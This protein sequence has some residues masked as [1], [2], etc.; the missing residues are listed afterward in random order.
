MVSF[1]ATGVPDCG[2]WFVIRHDCVNPLLSS[3]TSCPSGAMAAT[4]RQIQNESSLTM[5]SSC[6]PTALGEGLRPAQG[7]T[8]L[9]RRGVIGASRRRE[10]ERRDDPECSEGHSPMTCDYHPPMPGAKLPSCP[11]SLMSRTSTWYLSRN[12]WP[13]AAASGPPS[14]SSRPSSMMVPER[15]RYSARGLTVIDFGGRY[16]ST[17]HK[18]TLPTTRY[19]HGGS[20]TPSRATSRDTLGNPRARAIR[21]STSISAYQPQSHPSAGGTC[22]GMA[23]PAVDD[24]VGHEMAEL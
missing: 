7:G 16:G 3:M 13:N 19:D 14:V 15:A 9:L 5:S 10:R 1:S 24:F 21:S 8:V 23:H 12:S 22:A 18:R 4:L 2:D 11:R 17:S 20:A 6:L